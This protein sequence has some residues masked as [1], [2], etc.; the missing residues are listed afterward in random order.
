MDKRKLPAMHHVYGLSSTP[1]KCKECSNF[2]VYEYHGKRYFKCAA[3]GIS[4]SEATDWCANYRACGWFNCSMDNWTPLFD[5]IKSERSNGAPVPIVGQ[6][7]LADLEVE[8]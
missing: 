3:Y 4:K 8:V 6:V 1:H 7:T 5:R 2:H